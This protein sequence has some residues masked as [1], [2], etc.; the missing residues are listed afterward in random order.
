M[1]HVV[2]S[3]LEEL[4]QDEEIVAER[5]LRSLGEF[6]V[7]YLFANLGSDHPSFLEA[8]GRVR[9]AGDEDQI[10]S[11]VICPHEFPAISAAHGY[12]LATGHPQA[13]LVHIDVGTQ[14]LGAG[15]HNA[16]RGN[17]P[18]FI[19]AGLAA[20]SHK[21]F[22]NSR[23]SP[24]HYW[25][26]VFDQNG[27]HREYCR[28]D[29]EYRVPGDPK[30]LVAR[31]IERA[32]TEP[33]GPV[34]LSATREALATPVSEVDTSFDGRPRRINGSVANG[35]T[36]NRLAEQVETAEH[37]VVIT[38]YL[39]LPPDTAERMA[40]LVS[41]A[42]TAGAGV[43]EYG[44]IGQSFPRDHELHLGFEPSTT[45]ETADFL[46]AADTDVP[47][48]P[49]MGT[50]SED[51]T[52]IQ[53]DREPTKET[54]PQWPFDIDETIVADP[55][56]T[57]G[58][59][60]DQLDPSAGALGRDHWREFAAERR[61]AASERVEVAHEADRLTVDVLGAAI[62]DIVD[63]Y[64]TIVED[65]VT[66]S[67]KLMEQIVISR[68]GSY[69]T[70]GASGLGWGVPAAVGVKLARPD[71]LVVCITGDGG[72]L[73]S[74]PSVCAWIA[75]D[76]SAPT[77]TII[78]DNEGWNAV[79][80]STRASYPSGASAQF[81]V[82]ESRF[83]SPLDLRAAANAVDS[84]TALVNEISGLDGTLTEAVDAVESGKPAVVV[85][86]IGRS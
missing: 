33:R 20:V 66:S 34:Y 41:F 13:V 69:I 22:R 55:A 57:L 21:G 76:N 32:T 46:I 9:A 51:A 68:P 29:R 72:Y 65:A 42:E 50:P 53:I 37:P 31:G 70:N 24:V 59:I 78:I 75:A 2:D 16:L 58:A 36:V 67:R 45:F 10:P 79:E 49:V 85:A 18:V 47:W 4:P 56:P 6:G 39:G 82:P 38:S 81:G 54:Y 64:T 7:Q 43:I 3:E 23:D 19:M 63:E 17:S 84:Y 86:E 71:D 5:I 25:Q 80:G 52:V 83:K 60:T 28:W 26:D 74:V 35:A 44:S 30:E 15:I 1:P 12:A 8:I 14:N 77:L 48:T 40:S 27:I 62:A 61:A 11:I 73:F